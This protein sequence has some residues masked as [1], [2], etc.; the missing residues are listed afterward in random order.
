LGEQFVLASEK[1]QQ[2]RSRAETR[3]FQ[4]VTS[5]HSEVVGRIG[6]PPSLK[7]G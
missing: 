4:H 5:V 7:A 1:G 6:L 2:G 3:T